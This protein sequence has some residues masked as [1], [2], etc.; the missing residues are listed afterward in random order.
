MIQSTNNYN[1]NPYARNAYREVKKFGLQGV[2]L[3]L[4]RDVPQF[5]ED[6]LI[7][8]DESLDQAWDDMFELAFDVVAKIG[9]LCG[10]HKAEQARL[11][12]ENICLQHQIVQLPMSM[13]YKA[14]W[15]AVVEN[16]N[17][18]V[19]GI[20]DKIEAVI[21]W[22]QRVRA[23]ANKFDSM[24]YDGRK[25]RLLSQGALSCASLIQKD[26]WTWIKEMPAIL[27]TEIKGYSELKGYCEF[28]WHKSFVQ[29]SEM[30]SV[31]LK[32]L[33]AA[34]DAIIANQKNTMVLKHA[35]KH[36]IR[37]RVLAEETAQIAAVNRTLHS[38]QKALEQDHESRP[39]QLKVWLNR[40]IYVVA[41]RKTSCMATKTALGLWSPFG[42]ESN[43]FL[44]NEDEN[45]K[46]GYRAAAKSING[47][48]WGIKGELEAFSEG[49]PLC[50][51]IEKGK[52]NDT[53]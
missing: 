53:F 49:V 39:D 3:T 40:T 51:Y 21:E 29:E 43:K 46:E 16:H 38:Q 8:T 19:K 23:D 28:Y 9:E 33:T 36:M 18:T 52:N 14:E 12:A 5:T 44:R 27:D 37:C 25:E 26:L 6:G 22:C 32:H 15:D 50:K 41:H 31:E 2:N 45:F 47:L 13:R 24:Q 42:M 20:K 10:V 1:I 35:E 11:K 48:L 34:S 7:E 17:V 30:E 4:E